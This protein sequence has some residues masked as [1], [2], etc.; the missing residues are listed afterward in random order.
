MNDLKDGI[1][2]RGFFDVECR[3]KKGKLKWVEKF[4][5]VI[6][7]EGIDHMLNVQFNGGAQ[8]STWY[9]GIFE[10]NYTPTTADTMAA[11]PAAATESTAYA[12]ANRPEFEEATSSAKSITNTA[13]RAVFTINATKTIYGAFIASSATKSDTTGTLFAA[14]KFTSSRAV[15]SG[16]TISVGYTVNAS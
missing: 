10:G 12:E 7:D 1:K 11:F 16:D 8:V 13:N 5:N 14:K 9:V 3:D 15:V 6:T 4:Q 2:L